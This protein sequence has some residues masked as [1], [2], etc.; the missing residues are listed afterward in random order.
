MISRALQPKQWRAFNCAVTAWHI[1]DWLW[2]DLRAD[3]RDVGKK[4]FQ[5]AAQERCRELKLCRHIANASKHR[6]LDWGSDPGIQVIVRAK[7]TPA[8]SSEEINRSRHWEVLISDHGSECDALAVFYK[9][10]EFAGSMRRTS[11]WIGR[12]QRHAGRRAAGVAGQRQAAVSYLSC[13]PTGRRPAAGW[14]DW[15]GSDDRAAKTAGSLPPFAHVLRDRCP[16]SAACWRRLAS[17]RAGRCVWRRRWR[18]IAPA[19]EERT[20]DRVPLQ[21]ATTLVVPHSYIVR[22]RRNDRHPYARWVETG[23]GPKAIWR[24]AVARPRISVAR[25][26]TDQQSPRGRTP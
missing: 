23:N 1:A 26:N 21:W 8:S 3:G 14:V 4:Q 10:Q 12:S 6:G 2:R 13:V 19:L 24:S 7:D 15:R 9:V 22:R 20:R 16:N 17:A 18:P 25:L 5:N 11:C